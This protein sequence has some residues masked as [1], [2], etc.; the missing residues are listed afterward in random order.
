MSGFVFYVLRYF[1]TYLVVV[2]K[3]IC[4]CNR[5]IPVIQFWW[6]VLTALS[7]LWWFTSES[8]IECHFCYV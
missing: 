4:Q 3:N 1:C 7:K 8:W 5:V 2:V 6:L